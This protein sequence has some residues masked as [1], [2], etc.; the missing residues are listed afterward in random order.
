MPAP[1]LDQIPAPLLHAPSTVH[2]YLVRSRLGDAQ[3]GAELESG[4]R[5]AN[6]KYSHRPDLLFALFRT[7][8]GHF[9]VLPLHAAAVVCRGINSSRQSIRQTRTAPAAFAC[10]CFGRG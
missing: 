1:K 2:N 6:S 9:Y 4:T 10:P 5:P 8:R 7:E 3:L